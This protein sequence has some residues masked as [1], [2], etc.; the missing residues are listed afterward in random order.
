M[1]LRKAVGAGCAAIVLSLVPPVGTP[2][3]AVSLATAPRSTNATC[4]S[5]V[6]PGIAPP[7]SVPSGIPGFHASWYGQSGYM[8][9]CPGDSMTA[10]VAMYN[11]G[12]FGWVRGVLGQVAYLGTWSPSPGQ[13]Q[14]STFGGD[15]TIG[16]PN[17][18]WPRYNRVAIEP[19]AYVGPNQI[20]WFQFGVRAP[21]TPGSYRFYIRPLIE[22]AQWMEDYGIYWQITVPDAGGAAPWSRGVYLQAQDPAVGLTA[23]NTRLVSVTPTLQRTDVH[24]ETAWL[25]L[26]PWSPDGTAVVAGDRSGNSYVIWPDSV[27][28]LAAQTNWT[29]ISATTLSGIVP[30]ETTSGFQLLRVDAKIG[31]VVLRDDIAGDLGLSGSTVSPLGYWASYSTSVPDFF[32][33]AVTVSPQGRVSSGERT[34]PVGWLPDGRFVFIRQPFGTVTTT[35]EVRDPWVASATVVGRFTGTIDAI[36][37]P[38]ADVIVVHDVRTNQF[39]TIRGA[40]QRAVPLQTAL[41]AQVTLDSISHDGRTVSFSQPGS[42]ASQRTGTID[43]ESGVV[44]FMCS[45]GCLRL[46]IN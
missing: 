12:S 19:S 3:D 9:L 2:I 4:T 18:A 34:F 11:S 38:S 20:A 16:S 27:T 23:Q 36:A 29:W 30:R 32:G 10:T 8:T 15:G 22:G 33:E 35:V 28:H 14:P 39:W 1:K 45:G 42:G 26:G 7:A 44:T 41:T 21:M 46:V 37:Q 5:T 17:T 13:D 25:Y 6:G 40:V 24:P 31:S 43:L